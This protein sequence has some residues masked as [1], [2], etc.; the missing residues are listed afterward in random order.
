MVNSPGQA[1]DLLRKNFKQAL[2]AGGGTLN[3]AFMEQ[4]LIDEIYLDVE[5]TA[6]GDGIKLFSGETF[7]V[8]LELLGVKHLSKNELQL[9]YQVIHDN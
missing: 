1:V 4:G 5:P 7:D 6:L 2:V 9:H 8:K 3:A